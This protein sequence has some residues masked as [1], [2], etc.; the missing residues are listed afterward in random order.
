MNTVS[1]PTPMSVDVHRGE[2]QPVRYKSSLIQ[3]TLEK[4]RETWSHMIHSPVQSSTPAKRD[5]SSMENPSVEMTPFLCTPRAA[6]DTFNF[7]RYFFRTH[8]FLILMLLCNCFSV[9]FPVF[10]SLSESYL[11]LELEIGHTCFLCKGMGLQ[12]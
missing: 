3:A 9:I 7:T 12:M 10:I 4:A 11:E 6:T 5:R 2:S 1:R 8:I